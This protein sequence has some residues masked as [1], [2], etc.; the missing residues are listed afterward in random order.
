MSER[1]ACA[2]VGVSRSASRSEQLARD[3]EAP[4]KAEVIRLA[5]RYG[6]YGY[7]I[8][9][10]LLRNAGCWNDDSF[11]VACIDLPRCN[12]TNDMLGKIG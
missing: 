9:T 1:R 4:L 5:G 6:R 7:R 2:L 12:Q 8:V 11:I 10:G 3:D